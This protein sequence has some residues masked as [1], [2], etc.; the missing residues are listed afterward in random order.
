[1]RRYL[2]LAAVLFALPM[3]SAAAQ[4]KVDIARRTTPNFALRLSGPFAK[5]RVVAWDHDSISIVGTLPKG[6]RLESSFGGDLKLPSSGAKMFIEAPLDV[7]T[8]GGSLEMRVP[9]KVRLLVKGNS[10]DIDVTGVTGELD[11]NVIG[12]AVVVKA[13]P[14]TLN[15]ETMD[16]GVTF[17]GNAEWMRIKTSEGDITVNGRGV[18]AAFNTL[19]GNVRVSEGPFEKA[20]IETVTGSVTFGAD[21][22]RAAVIN[23]TTHSGAVELLFGPTA[24]VEID[25]ITTTATIENL[26]TSR[27]AIAGRERGQEI[28]LEIGTGDGRVV[29]RTFRGSIRL[30]KRQ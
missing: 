11:L 23:V 16:A 19:S 7:G 24:S 2:T 26:L 4:Q 27:R 20:N 6:H 12:G 1:M 17:E 9:R 5:L 13:N 28:G 30:A 25:A 8:G 18:D 3:A 29:I 15:I 22:A 21:F 14:Q 10:A